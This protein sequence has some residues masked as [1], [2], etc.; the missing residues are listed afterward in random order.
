LSRKGCP[1]INGFLSCLFFISL[2]F[3]PV[4]GEALEDDIERDLQKN[5]K[6]SKILVHQIQTKLTQ[7]HSATS[8][9]T[10]LKTA[11]DNIRISHLLLEERFKL[12]AEK[13][14]ALGSKAVERQQIMAEG[15]QKALIEYLGLVDSLMDAS[16]QPSAISNEL[17]TISKLNAL[18]DKLLPK[19]TRPIIGSLPYK[20]LNYPSREPGT[21]AIIPAYKGGNKSVSPDDTKDTAE[22]PISTE[23]ATLA[24]SLHWNPVSIYEYVKNNIDTEWYWG[25]MKG[26]MDTLHQ[27]S[28]NDCDQ[29]TL[30]AALLRASQFPTRY[31]HGVIEFFPD[32]ERAKNNTGIDDPA[33]ISGFFQKAG[34]PYKPIIVGGKI[35]NIQIE[36]VWIESLIPYSNYRGAII[37]EHGKTWLGLDTSIKAK[38]YEYNNPQDILEQT[39]ISDQL[40]AVRDEYL[41]LSSAVTG[42]TPYELKQTPLE[43]FMTRLSAVINDQSADSYKLTKA[44]IPEVL[45]ILP[46]SVQFKENNIIAEYTTIPE[47]LK[48]RVRFLA[49][50]KPQLAIDPLFDITLPTYKLS[51]QQIALS[52][53]PETVEDQEVINSYGG[54][55]LT[56]AYLVRLRP[57]LKINNERII[58]A[59]DGLPMGSEYELTVELQVPG[60]EL[61]VEKITNTMIA[62][63]LSVIG[64]AAGKAVSTPLP[65]GNEGAKDA[66]RLLYEA[67]QHYLDKWNKAEDDLA[68][69]LHLSIARPIPSI[70]TIGG[71]IDVGYLLDTPHEFTW[72]GV[73]IDADVRRIEAVRSSALEKGSEGEKEKLFMQLSSLQGSI[74]EN[75]IFEDD[76]QVDSIST[77]KLFQLVTSNSK[78]RT[79]IFTIDKTNSDAIIPTLPFDENIKEE[80]ANAVNQGYVLRT[81]YFELTYHDWSG[82]GYIKENPGKSVLIAD[83]VGAVAG[84]AIVG[85]MMRKKH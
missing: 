48:H 21:A 22:A 39:G 51:N 47:A 20:N 69:L 80:M 64:I 13:V 84:A 45:N 14:K 8:E 16:G 1:P 27:K 57:V 36:H 41:G 35:A 43:Y 50:R 82:I 15:Y 55:D 23:I 7:G 4:L 73:F 33:K 10:Q 72:K 2:F 12:R 76:F 79:G 26:A 46:A 60:D 62:G 59:K 67:G 37:D 34:I 58:V 42:S 77:A 31:V 63:N 83:G 66:E 19:R 38:G 81:P 32:I 29:A 5:L 85:A 24:Q 78:P 11:T 3:Y 54:L 40:S 28:G 25:C 44:L 49:T 74:L 56:P 75:K 17:S 18:L 68:S 52:Y 30:L 6:Q 61:R 65:L 71:V 9:I 70:V 53:E